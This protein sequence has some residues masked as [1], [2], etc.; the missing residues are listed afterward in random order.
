MEELLKPALEAR[1]TQWGLAIKRFPDRVV[2]RIFFS[3]PRPLLKRVLAPFI[4]FDY[5]SEMAAQ[6]YLEWDSRLLAGESVFI[7]L[8]PTLQKLSSMDFCDVSSEQLGTTPESGYPQQFDYLKIR[9]REPAQ[10]AA[11]TVYLPLSR[12]QGRRKDF[13]RLGINLN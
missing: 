12:F 11:L 6:L 4:R 1:G 8:D 9:I 3:I 10:A 13:G 2:P 5:L 7:S